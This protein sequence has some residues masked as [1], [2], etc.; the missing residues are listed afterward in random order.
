M[1]TFC[2]CNEESGNFGL[3]NIYQHAVIIDGPDLKFTV[4]NVVIYGI[5]GKYSGQGRYTLG[6][7]FFSPHG[8]GRYFS[9]DG[10]YLYDVNS[11]KEYLTG[12]ADKYFGIRN[13]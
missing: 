8:L 2:N 13:N 10:E 4:E 3:S 9:D 7:F 1:D 6:Y 11:R 12:T 5:K